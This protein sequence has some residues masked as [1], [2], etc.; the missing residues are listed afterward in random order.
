M[1]DAEKEAHTQYQAARRVKQ[2]LAQAIATGRA[3]KAD[4][5]RLLDQVWRHVQDFIPRHWREEGKES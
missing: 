3:S 1:T 2:Q 5:I 4:Q